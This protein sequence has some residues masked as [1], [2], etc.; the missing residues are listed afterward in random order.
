[1]DGARTHTRVS[2]V[3]AHAQVLSEEVR[4]YL[5]HH[6]G[7]LDARDDAALDAFAEQFLMPTLGAVWAYGYRTAP[8]TPITA[9]NDS[10]GSAS[11]SGLDSGEPANPYMETGPWARQP[12]WHLLRHHRVRSAA[13]P[14]PA[15]T[16][17]GSRRGSVLRMPWRR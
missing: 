7:A 6:G 2:E 17:V 4:T 1:M 16:A 15:G 9:A 11:S 13:R 14:R 8:T 5:L 12:W 10:P 3:R